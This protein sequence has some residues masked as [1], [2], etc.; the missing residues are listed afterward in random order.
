MPRSR[1]RRSSIYTPTRGRFVIYRAILV[2]AL[3]PKLGH[4]LSPKL[5]Q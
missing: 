2:Q 5:G 4:G 3:S 1:T